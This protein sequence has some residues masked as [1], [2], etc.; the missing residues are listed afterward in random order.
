VTEPSND[1]VTVDAPLDS[2]D[3]MDAHDLID[4]LQQ[5]AREN[6]ESGQPAALA[7]GTFALY[8]MRDGG[9]MFV[10]GVDHGPMAGVKHTRIPPGMIRAIGVIAG[11]GSKAQAVK[12]MIGI[13]KR[14]KELP[15][16]E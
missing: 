10:T 4:A 14:R 12:A 8:A 1:V 5:M 13:G 16:G 7:Q 2:V 9:A 6:D 3:V 15:A 11:G